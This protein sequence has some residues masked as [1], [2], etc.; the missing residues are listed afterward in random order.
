MSIKQKAHTCIVVIPR[1]RPIKIRP[2]ISLAMR[3]SSTC[4]AQRQLSV[5][6][7]GLLFITH[8]IIIYCGPIFSILCIY[9]ALTLL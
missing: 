9:P 1:S 3:G 2:S 5:T 6:A 4:G 7:A 8:F